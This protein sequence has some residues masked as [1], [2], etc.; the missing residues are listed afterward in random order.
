MSPEFQRAP[1]RLSA[2]T[3]RVANLRP[4]RGK[5][6]HPP[7]RLEA[8][9]REIAA[10]DRQVT[11]GMH[12][13]GTR[14]LEIRSSELW[15]TGGFESYQQYLEEGAQISRR[16]AYACKTIAENFTD[17]AA[18]AHPARKLDAVVR[19]RNATNSPLQAGKLLSQRVKFPLHRGALT[20]LTLGRLTATQINQLVDDAH[21]P[22]DKRVIDRTTQRRLTALERALPDP[23]PGMKQ[24]DRVTAKVAPDGTVAVSIRD[25]SASD[26][27]ELG[28]LLRKHFAA[29]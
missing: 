15:K 29:R 2:A 14:L 17:A 3:L 20:T 19:Y 10:A 5:P 26:L 22:A 1:V 16:K 11:V 7:K 6:L 12:A 4:T 23:V 13:I 24:H 8:L 28:A 18:A 27:P 21:K 9:T 25:I